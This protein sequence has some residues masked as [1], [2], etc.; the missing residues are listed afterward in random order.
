M[1]EKEKQTLENEKRRLVRMAPTACIG[2]RAQLPLLRIARQRAERER[3][4]E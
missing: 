2:E 1:R 4:R 3:E